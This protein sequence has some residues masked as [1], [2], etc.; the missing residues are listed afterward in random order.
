MDFIAR[1]V[2]NDLATITLVQVKAV[3]GDTVD[4]QPMIHQIDG[5]GN[6]I[7]HGVIYALPWFSLRAGVAQIRVTPMPDDIGMAAFCHSDASSVKATKAPAPPSSRRRFDWS[8]GLYFGGFLG[9]ATTTFIDVTPEAV[10][11]TAPA[12]NLNSASLTHNGKNIG[13]TH[14]HS[15]VTTGSGASGAPV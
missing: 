8:D 11:I 6:A 3:N 15:G 13:A 5:A 4:V 10:T 14:T 7:P 2:V 9:Q 1:Q 12:I